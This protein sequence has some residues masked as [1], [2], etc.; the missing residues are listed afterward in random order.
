MSREDR[1]RMTPH[2]R[3]PFLDK[4]GGFRPDRN[5]AHAESREG[6]AVSCRCWGAGGRGSRIS[7]LWLSV[8][9]HGGRSWA[10]P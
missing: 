3:K 2:S 7:D 6:S 8:R 10:S 4:E 1:A 5:P 9:A